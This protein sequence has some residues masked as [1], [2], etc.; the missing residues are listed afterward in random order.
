MFVKIPAVAASILL[1]GTIAVGATQA[2]AA[3]IRTN[4]VRTD[5]SVVQ[6]TGW[7]A[8]YPSDA[9]V[10]SYQTHI[11]ATD[12][13]YGP[14]WS[15]PTR[16]VNVCKP[17][18]N[19]TSWEDGSISYRFRGPAVSAGRLVA[20]TR[21]WFAVNACTRAHG[22]IGCHTVVRAFW[23]S[24]RSSANLG[25]SLP[26]ALPTVQLADCRLGPC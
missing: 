20:H 6:P 1:A 12:T 5:A 25:Y 13:S 4:P 22:R 16:L 11:Y 18:P 17:S 15:T 7:I 21:Y 8:I 24:P 3:T 23:A 19:V 26:N 10:I 9:C 2:N 14:L